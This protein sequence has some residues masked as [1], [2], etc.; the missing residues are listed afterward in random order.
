MRRDPSKLTTSA[1]SLFEGAKAKLHA[2]N[3]QFLRLHDHHRQK[4]AQL[5]IAS[6]EHSQAANN[7]LVAVNKNKSV[8]ER[9]E[10]LI[11]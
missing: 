8:I 10:A 7:A 5:S 9:I 2:A 4:A 3:E 1:L 11:A 6:T